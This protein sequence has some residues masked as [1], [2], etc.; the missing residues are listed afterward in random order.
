MRLTVASSALA[1]IVCSFVGCGPAPQEPAVESSPV[2][3]AR[4]IPEEALEKARQAADALTGELVAT[5]GRE[6][7]AGGPVG[8]VEVC[9]EMAPE[10]AAAH[11]GNGV[12]VRRV[13]LK[14]RNPDDTP[15][16]YERGVLLDL[17]VR[18]ADGSLPKE[19]A[20]VVTDD[21]GSRLRYLRPLVVKSPCLSCHGDVESMEPELK[22]ILEE[23]YPDD[24]AVGYEEGDLRG[25][26]SVTV[27]LS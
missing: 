9:S 24:Q 12:T 21:T 4:E 20:E 23:R 17:E 10:I 7:G 13:T 6:L 25:A 2:E 22:S 5:L 19:V 8:A 16:E 18:H 14:V 26:V 15:D 1:L 3:T 27:D 11:S